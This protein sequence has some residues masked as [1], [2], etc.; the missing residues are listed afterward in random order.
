MVAIFSDEAE[1]L[2]D[3][4]N[5]AEEAAPADAV[6]AT[7]VGVAAPPDEDGL[8]DDVVLGHEAPVARVGGVVAVVAL[9]PVVCVP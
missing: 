6:H 8:A 7:A 1:P 4:V 3:V 9:H 2:L 5:E